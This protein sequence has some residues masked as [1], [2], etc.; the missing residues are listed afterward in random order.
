VVLYGCKP[1]FLTLN[2]EHGLRVFVIRVLRRISGP[3]R[4]EVTGGWRKMH[5]KSFITSSS[6]IR[7]ATLMRK[8]RNTYRL[9]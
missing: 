9:L 6:V 8:K 4:D 5:N 2:E 7:M 3:R 1:L